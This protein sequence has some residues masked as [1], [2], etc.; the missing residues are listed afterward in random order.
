MKVSLN[1]LLKKMIQ[2]TL[3]QLVEGREQGSLSL[4]GIETEYNGDLL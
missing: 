2:E 4:K 1:L 3:N